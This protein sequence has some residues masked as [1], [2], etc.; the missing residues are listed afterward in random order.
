[1]HFKLALKQLHL[2]ESHPV[3][4]LQEIIS[5]NALDMGSLVIII[6]FRMF[7]SESSVNTPIQKVIIQD[8]MNRDVGIN[9]LIGLKECP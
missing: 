7:S 2:Q 1:M 4:Q 6:G 8:V 3:L 5:T 9:L